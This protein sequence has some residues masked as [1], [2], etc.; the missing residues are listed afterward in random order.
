MTC[1]RDV[2]DPRRCDGCGEFLWVAEE[3]WYCGACGVTMPCTMRL[4]PPPEGAA[5][6]PSSSFP[7]STNRRYSPTM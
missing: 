7:S 6:G 5:P 1:R 4:L 2:A 3:G